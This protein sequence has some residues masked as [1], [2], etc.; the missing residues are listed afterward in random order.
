MSR[1]FYG[2]SLAV[3]LAVLGAVP[4]P[5]YDGG[6]PP[7]RLDA[8]RANVPKIERVALTR[9]EVSVAEWRLA[10][11]WD[12]MSSARQTSVYW[13]SPT[14]TASPKSACLS[15]TP[16]SGTDACALTTLNSSAVAG[17]FIYLRG[18]DY[19]TR[20]VPSASG[21][22]DD[23]ITYQAY[24]NEIPRITE[25]GTNPGVDFNNRDYI[26]VIG[27]TV[28]TVNQLAY[29]RLG[30]SYNEFAY[31]T[32][33]IGTGT[34][35]TGFNIF[36]ISADPATA[37]SHNW[38]HHNILTKGGTIAETP[39]DD[40]NDAHDL[41]GPGSATLGCDDTGGLFNLGADTT[42]DWFSDYNTIE[43][44]QFSYGAHHALKTNTRHNVVRRNFVHNEGAYF[45]AT[46][47]CTEALLYS[48]ATGTLRPSFC[49][50]D[51]YYGNRGITILNNHPASTE[52]TYNLIERNRSGPG[53]LPSDGN[54]ADSL[55]LGG[56]SDLARFNTMYNA[57][58]LGIF[59]R[60]S[61]DPGDNMRAYFNTVYSNGQGPQC[62]VDNSS[63]FWKGGV[64]LPGG[65]NGN[66]L[67]YNI[68][69][70]NYNAAQSGGG[71][72]GTAGYGR[73]LNN[74]GTGNTITPNWV[75]SDGYGQGSFFG[76]PLFANTSLA[77]MTSDSVPD[78]S[79][80]SS[81]GAINAAGSLTTMSGAGSATTSGIFT[82]PLFFQ[83]G[84]DGSDLVRANGTM[85]ADRV[86]IGTIT[87]IARIVSLDKTTG[88]V[89]FDQEMTWEDGAKVWLYSDSSDV[90][91]LH[92]SA[93]DFGAHEFV[94]DETTLG[95]GLRRRRGPD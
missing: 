18:G 57:N 89:T 71:G 47:A 66:V 46:T 29:I 81:S 10:S 27:L 58:E 55:T 72:V 17:D 40:P 31:N 87:N 19:N 93:P 91:V 13:V 65:A 26:R 28:D 9:I 34:A 37:N 56:D 15:E 82:D 48:A 24:S 51:G 38:L 63:G 83:D 8:I 44:N 78:L 69:Y 77:D 3:A 42:N 12:A 16:L 49:A 88:A 74:N 36:S 1:V 52:P 41:E 54:G 62:K 80:L 92:G 53:G 79:L 45:V 50:P 33:Q 7:I 73:E 90:I 95:R 20:I 68:I 6:V 75:T 61:G 43:D 22:S 60:A 76:D 23:R 32:F 5:A 84:T 14:G 30:S 94:A 85:F 2:L 4:T 70:G 67:I 39:T 21:T 59:F 11:A 35:N 64:R 86:A 25:V